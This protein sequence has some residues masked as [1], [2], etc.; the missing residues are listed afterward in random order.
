LPPRLADAQ[1]QPIATER[2]AD[3]IEKCIGLEHPALGY[4]EPR[5]AQQTPARGGVRQ[6]QL[7]LNFARGVS[8]SYNFLP[9]IA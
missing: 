3:G 8:A 1:E 2:A 7:D 4:T 6:R 9:T 5:G